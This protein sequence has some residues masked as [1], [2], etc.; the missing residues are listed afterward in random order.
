MIIRCRN[1]NILGSANRFSAESC[2]RKYPFSFVCYRTHREA[3]F[4]LVVGYKTDK[5]I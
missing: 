4:L 1:E 3:L 5:S 2:L